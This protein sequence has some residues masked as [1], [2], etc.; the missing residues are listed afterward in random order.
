MVFLELDEDFFDVCGTSSHNWNS[1]YLTIKLQICKINKST[2]LW[3][4]DNLSWPILCQEVGSCSRRFV[5][6]SID[7]KHFYE[8]LG[9][10]N[11]G[12]VWFTSK[13]SSKF[14][15]NA[16]SSSFPPRVYSWYLSKSPNLMSQFFYVSIFF[17][18]K[19]LE[20]HF[21]VF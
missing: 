7:T 10:I 21:S 17:W 9:Y 13:Q 16:N 14:K 2:S 18:K 12:R 11:Y 4:L 3:N 15:M 6:S 19:Y 5:A 20:I 8:C 1:K